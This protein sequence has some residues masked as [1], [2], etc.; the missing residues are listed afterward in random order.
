MAIVKK[1]IL[2]LLPVVLAIMIIRYGS[3]HT[4]FISI[5]NFIL[6]IQDINFSFDL[7]S[8]SQFAN[9]MKDLVVDSPSTNIGGILDILEWVKYIATFIPNALYNMF[10]LLKGLVDL[11]LNFFDVLVSIF[12]VL[13]LLFT[14]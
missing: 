7:S 2:F 9:S 10:Y 13:T 1:I 12:K 14:S 8:F 5:K 4:P 6:L 3:G 11:V